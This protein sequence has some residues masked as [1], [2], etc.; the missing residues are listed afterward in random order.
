MGCGDSDISDSDYCKF[1]TVETVAPSNR[2][3]P[4]VEFDVL[5]D[6]GIWI[7]S[8][9]VYWVAISF[10]VEDLPVFIVILPG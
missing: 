4:E 10:K 5:E 1:N 2:Q 9:Q 7:R 6:A 3:E 8:V